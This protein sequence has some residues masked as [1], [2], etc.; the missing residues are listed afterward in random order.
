MKKTT[1]EVKQIFSFGAGHCVAKFD[2]FCDAKDYAELSHK[3]TGADY[4]VDE[5]LTITR[6][7]TKSEEEN[8]ENA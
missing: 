1:F 4:Q 6:F 3:G 7:T 8:N 5:V 2:D